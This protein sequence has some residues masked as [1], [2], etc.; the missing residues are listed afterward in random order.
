MKARRY[1][2]VILAG[3][4]SRRFGTPKMFASFK[5]SYYFEHA[6]TCLQ[7]FCDQV[8]IVTNE[9]FQACFPKRY[10]ILVDN[11]QFSG[12]G[13]LAGIYTAM[14]AYAASHYIFLPCDM[15][16][17]TSEVIDKLLP[18]H[19]K[20]ITTVS[21]AGKWQPLVSIW[22][23]ELKE[24]IYTYLVNGHK[25]V[26]Q[27]IYDIEHTVVSVETLSLE[28]HIFTNVNTPKDSEELKK[29]SN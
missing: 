9:R 19:T 23:S 8:F 15:P 4:A 27:F 25:Q 12:S 3:G 6:Y 1:V 11:P 16:L 17:V 2:G 5:G 26:K 21:V 20:E 22:R 10:S 7:P 13:P 28:P 18:Y 14:Q 29:W 24:K